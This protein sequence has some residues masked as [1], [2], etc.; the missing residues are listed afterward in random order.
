[1]AFNGL[2]GGADDQ[3]GFAV[4]WVQPTDSALRNQ[5]VLEVYQR[6]Q[7]TPQTQLTFDAQLI[8]DPT[9]APDD[10]AVGVFSVRLRFAF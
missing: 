9:N 7:I 3:T 5:E 8:I 6:F 1:M 10:D 2:L 4:A